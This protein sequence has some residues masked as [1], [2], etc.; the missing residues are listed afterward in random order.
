M[1]CISCL[2]VVPVLHLMPVCLCLLSTRD[3]TISICL[4]EWRLIFDSHG[5]P[6]GIA[7]MMQ[8]TGCTHTNAKLSS[9]DRHLYCC[10]RMDV[11][12]Q[13]KMWIQSAT[14]KATGMCMG[15]HT[16]AVLRPVKDLGHPDA[17]VDRV[18]ISSIHL[19]ICYIVHECTL[20]HNIMFEN[21]NMETKRTC[22]V[23]RFIHLLKAS[24]HSVPAGALIY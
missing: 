12:H 22:S 15:M 24:T 4:H 10:A 11:K 20:K 2:H 16:R 17:L 3:W 7:Y 13:S 6:C 21:H 14:N 23:P 1:I 5:H 19:D 8:T 18:R 9:A